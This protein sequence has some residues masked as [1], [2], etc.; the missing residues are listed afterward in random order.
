MASN[1]ASPEKTALEPGKVAATVCC[2]KPDNEERFQTFIKQG[3]WE[4]VL[5]ELVL[6]KDLKG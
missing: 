6:R 5:P 3:E 2:Q 4:T 1:W